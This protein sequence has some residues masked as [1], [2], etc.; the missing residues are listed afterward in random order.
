MKPCFLIKPFIKI[1]YSNLRLTLQNQKNISLKITRTLALTLILSLLLL[2]AGSFA[3]RHGDVPNEPYFDMAPY[4]FGFILAVNQ[5]NFTIK[6]KPNLSNNVYTGASIAD[7]KGDSARL[8]G[9]DTKSSL[10]ITIG[11]LS[12]VRLGNYFDLRFIPSLSFG[13]RNLH[14]SISIDTNS[15]P[16]SI[17]KDIQSTFIDLPLYVKY[18]GK[19]MGNVRPYVIVGIKY[20]IDLG[21]QKKKKNSDD[22]IRVDLI[23]DDTY[24]EIGAGFDFYLHY[25]NLGTELKMAYGLNNILKKDNSIYTQGIDKLTSKI[26]QL[27]FTFK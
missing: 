20:S 17:N 21:T 26:F 5:M 6:T 27:A 10:G 8:L 16:T 3:Q 23:R 22:N 9:I 25:F 4:H 14:Y 2:P 1:N 7:L 13:Q 24:A 18:K 11:I 12:S 15:R 19:R